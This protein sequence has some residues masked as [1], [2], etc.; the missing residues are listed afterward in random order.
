MS[1]AFPDNSLHQ[2]FRHGTRLNTGEFYSCSGVPLKYAPMLKHSL[3]EVRFL[4]HVRLRRERQLGAWRS[5]QQMSDENGN[6]CGDEKGNRQRS[7]SSPQIP[8]ACA[9]GADV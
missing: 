2:S 7:H 4:R 9:T 1:M 3:P 8:T 5:L 6:S